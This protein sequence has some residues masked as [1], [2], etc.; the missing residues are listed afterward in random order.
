MAS[1]AR[2][3]PPGGPRAVSSGDRRPKVPSPTD[4]ELETCQRRAAP[5]QSVSG[6]GRDTVRGSS[7]RLGPVRHLR[8]PA[9]SATCISASFVSAPPPRPPH[10]EAVLSR[11][12]CCFRTIVTNRSAVTAGWED[13]SVIVSHCGRAPVLLRSPRVHTDLPYTAHV[14]SWDGAGRPGGPA[15]PPPPGQTRLMPGQPAAPFR[16]SLIL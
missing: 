7:A 11:C 1:A 9:A 12:L 16:P 6:C 2:S 10:F 14:P 13:Q 3:C 4:P 8:R 15:P 5:H